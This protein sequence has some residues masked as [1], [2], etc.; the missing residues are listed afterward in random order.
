M[1]KAQRG[2]RCGRDVV[3]Y[4]VP[5]GWIKEIVYDDR[6]IYI[7]V[8][9]GSSEE[10]KL[11]VPPF[12][13][14]EWHRMNV[15]TTP[16]GTLRRRLWNIY[17]LLLPHVRYIWERMQKLNANDLPNAERQRLNLEIN[18][19]ENTIQE[20]LQ[21]L[22]NDDFLFLRDFIQDRIIDGNVF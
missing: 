7:F 17:L 16:Q 10:Q 8:K 4:R 1:N 21:E 6:T 2:V 5:F 15:D 12:G 13:N 22:N 3:R 19:A 14:Y 11:L 18:G 20:E 9:Q